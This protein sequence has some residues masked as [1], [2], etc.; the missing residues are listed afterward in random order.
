MLDTAF[1][2]SA[3]YARA[4]DDTTLNSIC[5]L[6]VQHRNSQ[7]HRPLK[8]GGACPQGQL[9]AALSASGRDFCD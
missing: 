8:T 5:V 9:V 4:R 2:H 1:L 6:T 7:T 3:S